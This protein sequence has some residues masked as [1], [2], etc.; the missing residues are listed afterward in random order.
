[1][2]NLH[3]KIFALL[4][5]ILLFRFVNS[6]GNSSVMGFFVPVEIRHVPA[7]KIVLWPLTPQ[8]QVTIKGPSFLVSDVAASRRT[9][10]VEIPR[11]VQSRYVANLKKSDLALP[12]NVQ[13]VS[14][15]PSEIQFTFDNLVERDIPI[16]MTSIGTLRNSLRL[17]KIDLTPTMVRVKGPETR[18]RDL[19]NVQTEPVDLREVTDSVSRDLAIRMPASLAELN[20]S[21]VHLDLRV[22]AVR[23]ERKFSNL[24]VEIRSVAG[25][26]FTLSPAT[27]NIQISGPIDRIS[28]LKPEEVIP[29]VR[30]PTEAA[31]PLNLA[32]NTDLPK[33]LS[34]SE[35]D[36]PEVRVV[37]SNG[38][39]KDKSAPSK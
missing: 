18:I 4:G 17:E 33:D 20:V 35:I 2:R 22:A 28:A 29:F 6:E 12:P 32:V 31:I 9:F 13:L 1:M 39:P 36:P 7:D 15:D 24:A 38:K 37:K 16:E 26:K 11:D 19:I 14:V 23:S 3:I 30:V 8:A 34:V 27:V 21:Q 10:K 25:E 5:A